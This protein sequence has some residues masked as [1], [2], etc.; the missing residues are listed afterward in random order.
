MRAP[1]GQ[2]GPAS[3]S[4]GHLGLHLTLAAGLTVCIGA[5]VVEL[6]RALGGNGLSWAYVFEWPILGGFGIYM[7][8]RLLHEDDPAPPAARPAGATAEADPD[9]AAWEAY[10]ADLEREDRRQDD[11]AGGA[12][13]ADQRHPPV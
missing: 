12:E 13:V 7:W 3:P 2:V 8:W 1:V 4:R 5:F 6:V 9:L 11:P 10:V